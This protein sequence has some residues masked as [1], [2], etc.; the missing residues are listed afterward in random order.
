MTD[1]AVTVAED[2]LGDPGAH[3]AIDVLAPYKPTVG[4]YPV[5]PRSGEPQRPVVL[6]VSTGLLVVGA[7]VSSVGLVKVLWDAATVTGYHTAARVLEWTKPD[8]VS[9]LTIVMVLTIGAIGA[10]V[11][12]AAGAI[13][14]NAW[15]GRR[16][17]R[18]GG[19]VAFALSGLT[20]LLNNVA[21][22]AMIPIA[23]GAG[24]LWLPVIGRYLAAWA[25]IRTAPAMR[26]GWAQNVMYG[27]LPRYRRDA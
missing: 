19:I 12:T 9:F 20:Y 16:W 5:S 22:I 15:N 24:L 23:I 6:A 17:A 8:P 7:V 25:V 10:V 1:Q 21:M 2:H 4:A 27:I 18:I 13:A 14:Y 11:A 3:Q 26:R